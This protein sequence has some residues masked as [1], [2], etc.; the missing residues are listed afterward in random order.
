MLILNLFGFLPEKIIV[1]HFFNLSIETLSNKYE[2]NDFKYNQI[3]KAVELERVNRVEKFKGENIV[4]ESAFD[5]VKQQNKFLYYRI[6][7]VYKELLDDSLYQVDTEEDYIHPMS[8]ILNEVSSEYSEEKPT[9]FFS[10][11]LSI[12]ALYSSTSL[13]LVAT[14]LRLLKNLSSE[15]KPSKMNLLKFYS[16]I[17]ILQMNYQITFKDLAKSIT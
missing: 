14:G 7:S 17:Y 5:S 3:R 6:L 16:C 9:R 15:S 11:C 10:I 8:F 2:K 1:S 4:L 12:S 13:N